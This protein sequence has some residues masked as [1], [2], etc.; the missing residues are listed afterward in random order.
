MGEDGLFSRLRSAVKSELAGSDYKIHGRGSFIRRFGDGGGES[1]LRID[2]SKHG[3]GPYQVAWGIVIPVMVSPLWMVKYSAGQPGL[4]CMFGG[5]INLSALPESHRVLVGDE[6]THG[7]ADKII[8]AQT[9]A[10]IGRMMH[11]NSVGS[12]IEEIVRSDANSYFFPFDNWKDVVI[13]ALRVLR[14]PQL[15]DEYS[16]DPG[17][18]AMSPRTRRV[19][20][21]AADIAKR[22]V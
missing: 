11:I 16:E 10:A 6:I 21:E 14:E 13:K 20:E 22:G 18:K 4:G 17:W 3:G 5:P 15:I 9:R 12:L 1:V 19:I 2:G 8:T 7:N